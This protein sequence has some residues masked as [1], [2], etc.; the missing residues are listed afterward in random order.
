MDDKATD[1]IS[2]GWP[3][4]RQFKNSIRFEFSLYM[5]GIILVLM[6]A[7]GYFITDRYVKTVT[8]N[9]I[10]KVLIQARSY[11]GSTGKLIIAANGPDALLLNNICN[12]LAAD[13]SDIHWVGITD[14]DYVFLAHT[15]I[16]EVISGARMTP[17]A[18]EGF[19]DIP[20]EG[21]AFDRRGDSLFIAIPVMENNILVGYLGVAASAR[22]IIEARN[23]SLVTVISITI[24]MIL[25]GIP[26]TMIILHRKLRPLSLITDSLK[27]IDFDNIIIDIPH[28]SRNEFGYLSE[29][30]RVMGTRLNAAQKDIIEKERIARELEIAREIQTNIL[31]TG[32]PSAAAFE[33]AGAYRSAREVG[34]DYYDFIDFNDMYMAFLVADVSGK[35]LPGMLVM[36]LTRDII[37]R[38]TRN[39]MEPSLILSGVNRELLKNIKKGMFVTMFFGLLNKTTGEFTF[40][41][42]GHNPLIKMNSRTGKIEQLKTKGFPLGMMPAEAFDKRIEK[43]RIMLQNDDWLVQYTDGINEAVNPGGEEFGMDRF[44]GILKENMSAYPAD[45][46]ER[47]MNRHEAFVGTADQFDDITLMVMKWN[48][49]D[50]DKNN[51]RNRE[52][53]HAG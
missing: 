50:A 13:N 11:S 48:G 49:M 33:F 30:L 28:H 40:A 10:D 53:S 41:S 39:I 51:K 21:E 8:R 1:T 6:L 22:Q 34:G 20:R 25:L 24:V 27:K 5:S 43:G 46:I 42:A 23:R 32:Y 29:T 44:T 3:E 14:K 26:V 19:R 12:K 18:N 17:P 47:T 52:Y 45:L 16:K 9:T 35:S 2:R 38:L 15:N 7:T 36:L 31:P 37:K 4:A